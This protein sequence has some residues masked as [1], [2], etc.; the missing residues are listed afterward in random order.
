MQ[1]R[2]DSELG[3]ISIDNSVLAKFAGNIAVECFGIVGMAAVSV[4]DGIVKLV[5]REHLAK[6][7]NVEVDEDNNVSIDFH[8][9]VAYGVSISAVS[10]N[11]I[12][13]VKY[14]VEETTG[15]TVKHINIFVEG[16]R[17]ID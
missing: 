7:V 10:D 4:T 5:K 16:V 15:L 9:I 12:S 11:L 17:V 13:T 6:G 14:Q 2:I 8:V 3:D 1:G